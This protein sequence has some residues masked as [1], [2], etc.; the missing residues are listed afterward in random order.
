MTRSMHLLAACAA[1][2]LLL[3]GC[4]SDEAPSGVA[5]NNCTPAGERLGR[6]DD[7]MPSTEAIFRYA[8]EIVNLGYR[9]SGTESGYRAAAYMKCQ[10][11]AIGLEDVQYE[12]AT[13]WKWE[14][15]RHELHV[16][17]EPVDSFPIAHS[18][19]TPGE[20]SR[21]S[22]GDDGI[23]TE[24]VDVGGA[25]ALSFA[26][27]DV[28]GKLV[29]FDLS[30]IL[31][32][33]GLLAFGEYVYD[34]GLTMV[35][36]L[37]TLFAANPYITNITS[38]V[39]AAID[40]GAV[41]VVGV[42]SDYFDSNKYYN[43][44]YRDLGMTIPGVWVTATEG[45]RIRAMMDAA[46]EPLTA[47]L[48]MSGSREEVEARTVVGFLPGNSAETIQVQSH[49]D[50]V[51][52]GAVEDASGSAEVLALA[53]YYAQQPPES[54]ERTL[55]F[56]T[57]DSHF[58][59]Y[60]SH[61]AFVEKYI[62]NNETPYELVA[63]V[64]VE[65]VAKQAINDDGT[66]TLTGSVEPRGIM[67][68]LAF[69]LKQR[70]IDAVVEHDLQRTVVMSANGVDAAGILLGGEGIP[71]DASFVYVAGVPTVSYIA[72]PAYLYDAADTLDKIAQDELLPVARAMA[73]IIDAIDETPADR[74]GTRIPLL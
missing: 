1:G 27:R 47:R 19:I 69:P 68:N 10:F 36:P 46:E 29:L 11:E 43:E 18:F 55:M 48:V 17:G 49:H 16:G 35:D 60:Q 32:N 24:I 44:F 15:D 72:G 38:A 56:S 66:L 9:R 23:E 2:L 54:R 45:E 59:G 53:E 73:D 7:G 8:E 14:S 52:D 22:T 5:V 28:E 12:T 58:T 70:I 41:G 25:G 39:E 62:T 65:H 26:T 74:I 63:N 57:F 61:M 13:T 34:P 21:F 33:A 42:L 71:T 37:D 20:P 51:F 30:F 31:A 3:S 67:E 4:G 40:A 64:T 6:E 50:S